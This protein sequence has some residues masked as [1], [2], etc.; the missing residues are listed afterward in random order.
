[1]LHGDRCTVDWGPRGADQDAFEDSFA[2]RN[3]V[4]HA[5]ATMLGFHVPCC[6]NERPALNTCK[7]YVESALNAWLHQRN[8][9][10]WQ[11]Q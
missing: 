8:I 4:A 1:V 10:E 3:N 9:T 5:W 2:D 6:V 7:R 11:S